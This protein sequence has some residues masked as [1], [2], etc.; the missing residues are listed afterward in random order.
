[1][2]ALNQAA[3]RTPASA[4][5]PLANVQNTMESRPELHP[6]WA[7]DQSPSKV[8]GINVTEVKKGNICASN[9]LIL[10][11]IELKKQNK[12][13]EE[14]NAALRCIM[15]HSGHFSAANTEG[16]VRRRG[17]PV[18]K[19]PKQACRKRLAAETMI[20]MTFMV[21]G[22]IIADNMVELIRECVKLDAQLL[23][24]LS[25]K[26]LLPQ[27][28][29]KKP[30]D[31]YDCGYREQPDKLFGVR[32]A[33]LWQA[34]TMTKGSAIVEMR[35]LVGK[36]VI[37]DPAQL[38]A[39]A[40]VQPELPSF[41]YVLPGSSAMWVPPVT[42]MEKLLTNALVAKTI[43][44]LTPYDKLS[45]KIF[46]W[47]LVSHLSRIIAALYAFAY[48]SVQCIAPPLTCVFVIFVGRW[49]E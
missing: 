1:M 47:Y 33:W 15:H 8:R 42:L 45:D 6:S 26:D 5:R 18:K 22:P 21:Q 34:R 24:K 46:A 48:E 10:E 31:R 11:N 43:R 27:K 41:E 40:E 36:S 3:P 2:V 7:A 17:T 29:I 16:L 28:I 19:M 35:R 30:D 9:K 4:R 32:N 20:N 38:Q 13:L 37:D 49:D 39:W 44:R 12:W 25:A 23:Q 14:E